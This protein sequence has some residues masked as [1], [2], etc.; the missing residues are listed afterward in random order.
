MLAAS[1]KRILVLGVPVVLVG[2][3]EPEPEPEPSADAT[4]T[5]NGSPHEW[6]EPKVVSALIGDLLFIE[7]IDEAAPP[8]GM[9]MWLPR[10]QLPGTVMSFTDCPSGDTPPTEPCAILLLE[11]SEA[12][13]TPTGSIMVT[14]DLSQD[15]YIEADID[16]DF[17]SQQ[18]PGRTAKLVGSFTTPIGGR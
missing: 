7:F 2:C 14:G 5:V 8:E 17:V 18:D 4:V 12:F 6:S 3:P 1:L 10:D 16:M 13:E 15:G 11:S 9:M